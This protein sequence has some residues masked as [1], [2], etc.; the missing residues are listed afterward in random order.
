LTKGLV[1]RPVAPGDFAAWKVLWDGYNAFYGREG[2]TALP[3]DITRTTWAR[4]F[5]EDEPMF[6]WVAQD[7]GS[8][9]GL[10]HALL[11]RSTT[12]LGP[13]CYLQDLFTAPASRGRGTA[14]ALIEAVH[15]EAEK[16]G[17]QR[18][19]W[20]THE[21]NATAM[22]LYDRVA[23]RTGFVVYHLLTPLR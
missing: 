3:A 6:A 5:A 7:S 15:A 10:A 23:R 22:A 18:V 13:V 4:F 12:Q 16:R 1:I 19:Y 11:H 8:L 20:Q 9:V 17:C 21:T 14:G 2:A